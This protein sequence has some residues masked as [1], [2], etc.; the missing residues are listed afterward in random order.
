MTAAQRSKH[1]WQKISPGMLPDTT[2]T[3]PATTADA[4][5]H[6][7]HLLEPV[8]WTHH[9]KKTDFAAYTEAALRCKHAMSNAKK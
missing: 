6:E 4:Y 3:P 2:K 1:L 8:D 7:Q 9:L 5:V